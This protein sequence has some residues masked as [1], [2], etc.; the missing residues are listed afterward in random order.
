MSNEFQT[1]LQK[2]AD[3]AIQIG[4]DFKS[5]QRL[6]ISSTLEARELT[7]A[8]VRSAFR[9]GA[10][11]VFVRWSDDV[12]NKIRLE[13]GSE[14]SLTEF[15]A[16]VT[17]AIAKHMDAGG[18]LMG[19]GPSDPDILAGQDPKRMKIRQMAGAKISQIVSDRIV[20]NV[21]NWTGI[22]QPHPAISAKMFPDLSPEEARKK[23]WD[24]IFTACRI[25]VEDPVAAW[26]AH[27]AKLE[28]RATFLNNKAY[29]ALHYKAEGTDLSVGLPKGH[30]WASA[31][32][33]MQ[34]GTQPVVNIPT[35]EIFTLAHAD[36]IDGVVKSTK[37]LP[38]GGTLID[39][40][41][42]QFSEGS[43]VSGKAEKGQSALD[44]LLNTDEGARS[45]GELALVPHSSPISQSGLTFYSI[46]YDENA[47]SHIALGRAYRFTLEGGTEMSD[48]EFA[49]IGGNNSLVH[50]DFMVGAETMDIDGICEDGSREP[51]M[52][53]GEWAFE[54]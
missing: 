7:Q 9:A 2:Y 54:I 53:N 41:V 31:R 34:N 23:H 39:N 13:E 33:K 50:V 3:V 18:A 52:R 35:E 32:Q 22:N 42:L 5:G 37:P 16:W 29:S 25:N 51:V 40:F 20:K 49:E 30:I 12:M 21:S 10:L 15:P 6:I 43:V 24:A 4:L 47:S 1:L 8:V 14:E 48:E 38:F 11:D 45:I 44:N 19:I 26:K 28:A 46:L 17:N 36:Q 27:I